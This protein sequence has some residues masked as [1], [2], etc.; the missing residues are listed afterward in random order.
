MTDLPSRI[1][2]ILEAQEV[3]VKRLN[4]NEPRQFVQYRILGIATTAEKIMEAVGAAAS[5]RAEAGTEGMEILRLVAK[6]MLWQDTDANAPD[7][8]SNG[9]AEWTCGLTPAHV[10]QARAIVAAAALSGKEPTR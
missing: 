10:R 3:E 4:E 9:L 2:D 8:F 5:V 1:Q 6:V 7:T